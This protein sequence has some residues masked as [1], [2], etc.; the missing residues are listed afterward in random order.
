LLA[1]PVLRQ[2]VIRAAILPTVTTM[3]DR[4]DHDLSLGKD[5]LACSFLGC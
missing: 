1:D 3:D 2:V 4:S 5:A